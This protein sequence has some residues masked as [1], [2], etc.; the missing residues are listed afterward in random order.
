MFYTVPLLLDIIYKLTNLN[1]FQKIVTI[2]L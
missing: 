2:G 1:I